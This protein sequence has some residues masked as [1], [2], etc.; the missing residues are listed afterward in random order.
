MTVE[1]PPSYTAARLGGI[2]VDEAVIGVDAR[3][4]AI[5]AR[6]HAI[7][8]LGPFA[9]KSVEDSRFEAALIEGNPVA[10]RVQIATPLG[11]IQKTRVEPEYD[12]VWA[13]VPG[14]QP[15]EARWQLAQSVESLT[16]TA[17]L[18]NTPGAGGDVVA[19]APDGRSGSSS[20]SRHRTP[21][22]RARDGLHGRFLFAGGRLP[23]GAALRRQGACLDHADDRR[24]LHA[25]DR[26]RLPAALILASEDAKRPGHMTPARTRFL[27]SPSPGT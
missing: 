22:R 6:P 13:H 10:T 4:S 18:G 2:V 7:E 25:R 14:G 3:I 5:R 15:R 19:V 26:Q 20:A 27:D 9:Q 17:H 23:T 16:V 11:N 21:G 8:G 24:R 12:M 1:L